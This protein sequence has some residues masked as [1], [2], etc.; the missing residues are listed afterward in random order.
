[1]SSF[2]IITRNWKLIKEIMKKNRRKILF[3]LSFFAILFFVGIVV[4]AVYNWM[5]ITGNATIG[6]ALVFK[7]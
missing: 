3:L 6:S 5:N 4:A 7:F 1:L 2:T